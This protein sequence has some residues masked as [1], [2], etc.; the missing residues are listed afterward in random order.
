MKFINKAALHQVQSTRFM[1]FTSLGIK[2]FDDSP[3]GLQAMVK[4]SF[5]HVWRRHN[6]LDGAR[7]AHPSAPRT[8]AVLDADNVQW[9][10]RPPSELLSYCNQPD[11]KAVQQWK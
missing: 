7:F 5:R 4:T 3:D 6:T 10:E 8:A 9:P 11:N 2:G 1:N